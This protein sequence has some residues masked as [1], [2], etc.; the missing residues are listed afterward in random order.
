VQDRPRLRVDVVTIFPEA[1]VPLQLSVLGRAQR[2]GILLVRVWNLRDFTTDRHRTTDDYPYGGGPGMVMKAEPFFA[3]ARAIQREAG[4]LGRVILTSPQGRLFTQRMAQELSRA[5]HLV[6]LC[7]HYEGVDERVAVGLKAEEVSIGDYVLTGGELAA[8]VIV[9][10]TARL[11]PGVVGDELSVRQDSF[12]RGLLDHPHYTRPAEVEG[13]RV[14]E[15]LLSG[16]HKAIAR[17]RRKE[18][19]RRTLRRRPDLLETAELDE[20]DRALLE[21]VLR[22]ERES[23]GAG[24]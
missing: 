12:S 10:A 13:L 1:F 9:D 24:V 6:I 11:V 16:N 8:L 15:V 20:E 21:E 19:L 5:G 4:G 17:W 22:E 2:S 23:G 7:G 18:A 3:A 14:P